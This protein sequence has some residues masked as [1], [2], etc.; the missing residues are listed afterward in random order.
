M[1]TAYRMFIKIY[2]RWFIMMPR[3]LVGMFL[4]ISGDNW[5]VIW[6]G[7]E[8][9]LFSF[10]PLFTGGSMM[11]EGIIK[12]FL[13]QAGGSRIFV[14]SFLLADGYLSGK[15][16]ALGMLIKLG[17][18]PFYIWVPLVI[19]TI[20]WY[21]CALLLTVQKVGPLCVLWGETSQ[22]VSLLLVSGSMSVLVGGLMGYNQ[23]FMRSLISYSSI[24]HR[25]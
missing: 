12:Y 21:G 6:V 4:V 1:L 25:G 10:L 5:F 16:V 7:F 15:M 20:T 17:L 19:R 2:P 18:F 9:T 23:S 8:L 22:S 24:S 13:T 11:F 3:S 14:L